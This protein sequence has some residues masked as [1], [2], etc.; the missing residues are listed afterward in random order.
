MKD[1]TFI[2]IINEDDH[3]ADINY[4][5]L[6]E[7]LPGVGLVNDL[8]GNELLIRCDESNSPGYSLNQIRGALKCSARVDMFELATDEKTGLQYRSWYYL[9]SRNIRRKTNR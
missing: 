4:L 8:P 2:S 1:G 9:P 6:C 7:T 3:A 5:A